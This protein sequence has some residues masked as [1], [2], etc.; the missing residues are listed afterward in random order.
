MNRFVL[1]YIE[2]DVPHCSLTYSIAPCMATLTGSPPTGT[3]KCFNSLGTCQD[4]VNF[5]D[6]PVTMRFSE[7]IGFDSSVIPGDPGG[8]S[9]DSPPIITLPTPAIGSDPR[10]AAFPFIK[11]ISLTPAIVSLGGD[12]GQRATLKVTFRDAPHS[13]AGP[14]FDKYP[15]TRNY[16]PFSQG[17]F[18][19]K[20]RAR[21]PFLRNR[22]MRLIRGFVGQPLAEMETRTFIIESIDGPNVE[23][24][25]IINA[26]DILK[27]ADGDRSVAPFLSG[28]F[29][30][31]DITTGTTAITLSP[32]GIGPTYPE[33]GYVA[34]GGTEVCAFTRGI[35]GVDA[36]TLLLIHADGLD[37]GTTF[38]DSSTYARTVTSLGGV[39][40]TAVF[41]FGGSSLFSNSDGDAISIPA[42]AAWAFGGTGNFTFDWWTHHVGPL[43][44]IRAQFG[45]GTA[46]TNQYWFFINTDGSIQFQSIV[47]TVTEINLA[48]AAGVIAAD[49]MYH[50]ALERNGNV[51]T[52]YVDGVSV[53]TT[54]DT[55]ALSNYG[56]A[57]IIGDSP[58]LGDHSECY[59]DE[60]RISN[61]ARYAGNFTPPAGPYGSVDAFTLTR[62][63]LNTVAATHSASDRVQR[64]LRYAGEDGANIISDL[65]QTYAEVPAAYIPL[66]DWL[67]E[68]EAFLGTVFTLNICEP[69]P[70]RD[71][72]TELLTQMGAAMWWDDIDNLV[73][74]Q[75]LRAIST[76]AERWNEDN[77]LADTLE[78]REQPEKRISQVIVYFGQ[79]NPLLKKDELSNYR[80]TH[81]EIDAQ[82]E[83]DEGSA[84]IKTILARG[85]AQGGRT[86]ATRI[87]QKHLSRYTVAP[88][89]F[90]FELLRYSNLNP[91]LGIGIRL[92]GGTPIYPSWL[93]Q[94]ETGARVDVP[95]QLTRHGTLADRDII[96]AEEVLFSSFGGDIDTADR[97]I[98]LD[99]NEMNVNLKDRHDE[100]FSDIEAGDTVTCI[101]TEGAII[102]SSSTMLPAFD[103]GTW[104]AI[105][106]P[107]PIL[108]IVRGRIQGAGGDGRFV[109]NGRDGGTALYTRRAVTLDLSQGSGQIWG[110]GGGGGGY[111]NYSNFAWSAGGGGG[112][113]LIPGTADTG[114]TNQGQPGTTQAGGDGGPNAGDGGGPGLDG[115]NGSTYSQ[116]DHGYSGG[117]AGSAIDG[118]SFVTVDSPGAGGDIR[119]TQV[120]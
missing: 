113:G 9:A 18:W 1:T 40:R 70:V 53:A 110:G 119:G 79:I 73:R 48:S 71:L 97:V 30:Q 59:I 109:A 91:H 66:A 16:D 107:I 38:T 84:A 117:D 111:I 25:F 52:I 68:T 4:R 31:A 96:E 118:V 7:D 54:T 47:A 108:I 32:A 10:I 12:L 94:D 15:E 57:F 120:N 89:R 39:T 78:I 5:T 63:Q 35:G 76:T 95:I 98:I 22:P 93:F 77:V 75:I 6:V 27:L 99:A 23:G 17:T 92:G 21:N 101:I 62:G 67:S 45:T 41:K 104:P 64:V 8:Q 50:I 2:I 83:L 58:T 102:G 60:F 43:T 56:T 61:V 3:I 74:L 34:I 46:T 69:T 105:S 81:I 106:P 112:A 87:A 29:L 82:S 19:G 51:F 88:R 100:L 44:S 33:S 55:S 36:N 28:G 90:N 26:K 114:G 24:E 20:F 37:L 86:T 80:S 42:D 116:Y 103:V 49:T 11:N 13:D 85:I 72:I 14:N 65:L 115:A